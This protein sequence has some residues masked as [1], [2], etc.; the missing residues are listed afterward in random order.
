[1]IT[2]VL[3]PVQDTKMSAD[4]TTHVTSDSY[5]LSTISDSITLYNTSDSDTDKYWI[6]KPD[7]PRWVG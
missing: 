7:L 4:Y 2:T 5:T 3:I 1:M 6:V